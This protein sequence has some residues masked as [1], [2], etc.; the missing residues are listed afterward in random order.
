MRIP[1]L[2]IPFGALI[3][4]WTAMPGA[5][6]AGSILFSTDGTATPGFNSGPGYGSYGGSNSTAAEFV[7]ASSGIL[8][9]I[10]VAAGTI[11]NGS[12]DET[13]ELRDNNGGL[14]G[15]VIDTIKVA[16][17]DSVGMATGNSSLNPM[18]TAGQTYWLEATEPSIA[19]VGW[20]LAN[21]GV[22]GTVRAG[23]SNDSAWETTC[24][25]C[26]GD[27]PSFSLIAASTAATPEPGTAAVS[28]AAIVGMAGLARLSLRKSGRSAY[29]G[30]GLRHVTPQPRCLVTGKS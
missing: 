30:S 10:D 22:T 13:F 4:G 18:L 6:R 12:Y 7:A 29:E 19:L 11:G 27:L 15:T 8:S 23:V 14:P 3:L 25:P 9:M 21:P 17:T 20:N 1:K 26:N 24:P 28:L 2:I 5:A 16:L